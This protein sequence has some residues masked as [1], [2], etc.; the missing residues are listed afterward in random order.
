MPDRLMQTE[1]LSGTSQSSGAALW[2]RRT[3]WPQQVLA[4]LPLTLFFPVGVMYGGV[5]AFYISLLLSNGYQDKWQ[6]LRLSPM[7][8]PVL[9]LTVVSIA[10]ALLHQRPAGEFWSA[11]W[12]Y[13]TYLFLFPFLCVGS[14]AW[15]AKAIRIFFAGAIFAASLY[16]LNLLHLL[17]NNTLFRSYVVYE[18]NKSIL[19]GI[20]LAVASGWMLHELVLRRNHLLIRILVLIYVGLALLLLAKTRTASLIF[21]LLCVLMALRNLRCSWRSG[22][23]LACLLA[24][25]LG[26]WN[27]VLSLPAPATCIANEMQAAGAGPAQ[28]LATRAQCT[29][30]QIHSFNEGKKIG[31][32]GMRLEIY[33]ITSQIIAEQPLLGHGIA[34]WMPLYQQRAKG[35]MSGTM[36]TPHNDYL[37]YFTELGI[38]GLAALLWIWLTQLWL[39]RR[40]M[41][42]AQTRERAMLLAML[43][44]SMMVGGMFNAI[45]RDGVFGMAFMILL[46]IPLAGVSKAS[47]K[48]QRNF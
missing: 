31:E 36:T 29:V 32:D 10:A 2:T 47:E 22:L 46:A 20:L 30:H 12:H 11:F 17:P 14:G 38:A 26:I 42:H 28:I 45:L 8:P 3:A 5:L 4:W 33:K 39:A 44:L 1:P 27:Y 13:Q 19:L 37:L 16:Y 25:G 15:Q 48:N 40:M 35:L 9:G 23:A 24:A 34:H 6:C 18:G 41:Q 43:G 7:L 21:V